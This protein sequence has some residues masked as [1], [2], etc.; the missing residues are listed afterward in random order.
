MVR[1]V[2]GSSVAIDSFGQKDTSKMVRHQLSKLRLCKEP[3]QCMHVTI[4]VLVPIHYSL[5]KLQLGEQMPNHRNRRPTMLAV[6]IIFD[7]D[8][9]VTYWCSAAA[10]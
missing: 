3:R 5:E 4:P 2:F 9:P 8:W 7:T 6:L 10:P 1:D